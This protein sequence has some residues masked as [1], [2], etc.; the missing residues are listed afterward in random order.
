MRS[1]SIGL[2]AAALVAGA[3]PAASGAT[4]MATIRGTVRMGTDLAGV[5][6]G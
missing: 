6:A 2:V 1:V 3:A 4:F 5:F